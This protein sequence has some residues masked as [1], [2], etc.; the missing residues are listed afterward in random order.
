MKIRNVNVN[1]VIRISEQDLTN[2]DLILLRDIFWEFY[3]SMNAL[4]GMNEQ[5]KKALL[6]IGRYLNQRNIGGIHA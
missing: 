1:Q 3:P 5:L 6:K 2:F 4:S